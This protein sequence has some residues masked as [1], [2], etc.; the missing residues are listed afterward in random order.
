MQHPKDVQEQIDLRWRDAPKAHGLPKTLSNRSKPWSDK[1]IF[2]G[3]M[4]GVAAE[5]AGPKTVRIAA[6][7]LTAHRRATSLRTKRGTRRPEGPSDRQ[8]EGWH[9]HQVPC[10]H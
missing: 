1:R 10:R 6:T 2:A 4:E 7:N 5:A 9:E 8:G 3:M